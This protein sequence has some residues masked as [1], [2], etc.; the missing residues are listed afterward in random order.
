MGRVRGVDKAGRIEIQPW[1]TATETTIVMVALSALGEPARFVGGCVRD[2]YLG[3]S[4]RDIGDLDIDIAIPASPRS[5]IARLK[6]AGIRTVLT[7]IDHGTVTAIVGSAHFEI[8]SLRRDV[9]TFGRHARVAYTDNWAVDAKRRDFTMN[10]L[11]SDADGSLYDPTGGLSDLSAG[12]VRFVGDAAARIE[13]DVLRLLRFFRFHAWYGRMPPDAEA[14]AACRTMA[15]RLVELSAERVWSEMRRILLA[16]DPAAVLDLMAENEILDHVLPEAR[17]RVRL[18]ALCHLEDRLGLE[19]DVVRRLLAVVD[20]APDEA[21]RLVRRLRLS[22]REGSRIAA[23]VE[24]A[25]ELNSKMDAKSSRRA[26]YR[27]GADL[28]RDAA[29]IGW[30]GDGAAAWGGP[31]RVAE[32]WSPLA[33]PLNGADVLALGVVKGP[34]VGRVLGRVED[35]WMGEDFSPNRAAC[36]RRLRKEAAQAEEP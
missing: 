19:S 8:T 30:A 36:L 18:A 21:A 7:G 16:P 12:R 4:D 33:F 1:M 32:D 13:E 25:R 6:E 28:F 31:W 26:L 9:E 24:H 5:V 34:D 35:W 23:V 27:L 15:G 29:L 3:L 2:A 11:F 10:A 22:R 14:L 20:V 17:E